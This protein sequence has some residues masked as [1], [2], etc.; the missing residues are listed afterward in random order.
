MMETMP[1]VLFVDDDQAIL[2]AFRRLLRH[3]RTVWNMTFVP[4]ADAAIAEIALENFPVVV[5]DLA[6]PG[7]TGMDLI[8]HVNEQAPSS[9]CIILS[10]TADLQTATEIVNAVRVFRFY[11]KPCDMDD[12][13][14]GIEAALQSLDEP[15]IQLG[16]EKSTFDGS[17]VLDRISTALIVVSS[18][19]RVIFLNK[20]AMEFIGEGLYIGHDDVLR[21]TS[22]IETKNLHGICAKL[23]A[24]NGNEEDDE[25]SVAAFSVE[26][27][28]GEN[29][30][31][32]V[33]APMPDQ[34]GDGPECDKNL[35]VFISDANNQTIAPPDVIG[36]LFGLTPSESQL[37]QALASGQRL[38]DIAESLA[39]TISSARTYLKRIQQK[40]GTNRQVDLV[41]HILSIP[42]ISN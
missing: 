37:A 41:R 15:E 16:S 13:T 2:D 32:L 27:P 24:L 7:K 35:I 18:T 19:G 28:S 4:S 29:A 34:S 23:S 26:R 31:R 9:R 21:A 17:L 1:R 22:P 25:G 3:K 36:R 20:A 6:M 14:E 5:T 39:I 40:M 11:T 10:G 38:E 8:R 33:C 30:L 12:L 42:H